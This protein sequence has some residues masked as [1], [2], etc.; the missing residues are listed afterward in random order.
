MRVPATSHERP[1]AIAE[2]VLVVLVLALCGAARARVGIG[3]AASAANIDEGDRRREAASFLRAMSRVRAHAGHGGVVLNVVVYAVDRV[4]SFFAAVCRSGRVF[5]FG[6]C[7]EFDGGARYVAEV[8]ECGA[9]CL[10]GVA[11]KRSG[12]EAVH[13]ARCMAE[14]GAQHMSKGV[15]LS[16]REGAQFC[17]CL[18]HG[19]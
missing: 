8:V 6:C 7:W 5:R 14:E 3:R 1:Y 19:R 16:W 13:R 9:K 2:F 15:W 12:V 17:A 11:S 4:G 18:L 10:R